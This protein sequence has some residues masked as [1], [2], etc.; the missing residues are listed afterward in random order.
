M[1]EVPVKSPPPPRRRLSKRV[2]FGDLGYE[3]HPGQ[4][5]VHESTAPRRVLASGVR[6]GN[7]LCAAMEALA[8]AM[9]PRERSMG[10]VVAP[11]YDLCERVFNQIVLIAASHLRH[12]IVTLKEHERR[13]VL[14]N[15]GGGLSEIRGKSA[16]NPV[17]VL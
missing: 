13:L 6:W 10:W 4:L 9:E 11:T 1:R 17:S 16:D 12:R 3:P 8:A 7:T 5:A 2:L 15:M 14:R